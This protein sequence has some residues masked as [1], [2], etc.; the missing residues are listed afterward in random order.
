MSLSQLL[1]YVQALPRLEKLQLMQWLAAQLAKEEGLPFLSPDVEYP[2]WSPYDTH[3]A[4]ADLH[5]FL[6]KEKAARK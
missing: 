3:E 6:E 1:P 4:A 2:T 5:A